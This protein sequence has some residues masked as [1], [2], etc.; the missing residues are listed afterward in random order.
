MASYLK[1]SQLPGPRL[2]SA[3]APPSTKVLPAAALHW[4]LCAAV[5]ADLGADQQ[6]GL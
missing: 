4:L 5:L 1:S 6:V 3:N 2:A